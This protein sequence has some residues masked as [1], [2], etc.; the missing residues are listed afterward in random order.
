MGDVVGLMKDFEGVVDEKKAEQDAKRML[1]G[2][3]S[4]D[5]FLGQLEMLQ[6]MG[7]LQNM[8]EK[9]PFFAD[10]V[11]DGFQVDDREIDRTK[12]IVRS[13]TRAERHDVA[14]FQR[15]PKRVQ[16]VAKGSGRTDREVAELLQK[17]G[18]MK[19]IMGSIGQQAGMLSKIPGMKQLASMQ[20]LRDAVKT[21][22]LEGNPMMANLAD[23]LVEAAVAGQGGP[24]A[25]GGKKPVDKNKKK[26]LR[27]MQKKA[28]RKGRR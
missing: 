16:R 20:R 22:G 15:Q 2:Q 11:P 9:L 8:M 19:Q 27:Q 25:M 13:M 18:M 6:G 1:R 4:L 7:P 10:S 23:Q 24:R 21:G 14:L 3:F 17:F 26:K 12:A 5:D 28:R